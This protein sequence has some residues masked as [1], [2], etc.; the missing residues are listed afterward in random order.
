[1]DWLGYLAVFIFFDLLIPAQSAV[2]SISPTS[3][4]IK[5]N[6][7][8]REQ[9]KQDPISFDWENSWESV[10]ENGV[11]TTTTITF[12][13]VPLYQGLGYG[14]PQQW[15]Y[16]FNFS[17][18]ADSTL[19]GKTSEVAPVEPSLTALPSQPV[20]SEPVTSEP[21]KSEPVKSEPVKSEPAQPPEPVQ[22]PEGPTQPKVGKP[23][24]LTN[25]TSTEPDRPTT[26]G[27][28]YLANQP[29]L[30][31]TDPSRTD[32]TQDFQPENITPPPTSS[33]ASQS[34][35][36]MWLS[37]HN[38]YRSQYGVSSLEWSDELSQL[39]SS[40]A[41]KC[42]WEHTKNNPNGENLAAGQEDATS[43]VVAW[44]EGPNEREVWNPSSPSYS[45]FTQVVWKDT[46]QVGCASQSCR[47]IKGSSLPQSPVLL[48]VCQY[49]PPG[50]VEGEYNDNVLAHAGGTP[51][52]APKGSKPPNSPLRDEKSL[53][54]TRYTP[55]PTES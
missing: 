26:P 41:E 36:Q 52:S 20:S 10:T 40:R 51:L 30:S 11:T 17:S 16:S 15:S 2:V 25:T 18:E 5:T 43:T 1:M 48:W 8:K 4:T 28:Q 21:V 12:G 54:V 9:E 22:P 44:V 32:N 14:I 7:S 23:P 34:D 31:E 29:E 19:Q 37:I 45:H 6:L 49:H 24:E 38:S 35:Q 39:A 13:K 42:V 55:A 47:T 50:N 46:R 3:M 53:S 27:K 33:S